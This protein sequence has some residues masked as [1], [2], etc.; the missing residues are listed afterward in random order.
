MVRRGMKLGEDD[1][2]EIGLRPLDQLPGELPTE[3]HAGETGPTQ[4][5][6]PLVILA[7]GGVN[8]TGREGMPAQLAD[9]GG[10]A[11]RRALHPP[12]HR[13][14]GPSSRI[15]SSRSPSD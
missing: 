10:D 7:T 9:G 2:R 14:V 4:C 8:S 12:S 3:S 1:D 15:T 6:Q 5:T 11:G 13:I